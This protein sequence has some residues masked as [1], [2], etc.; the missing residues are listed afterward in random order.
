MS[1]FKK[2]GIQ[3]FPTNTPLSLTISVNRTL[4]VIKSL[5]KFR[6]R[7]SNVLFATRL[8]CNQINHPT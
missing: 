4:M 7:T 6:Y 3:I 1:F 5:P 8:T 2:I